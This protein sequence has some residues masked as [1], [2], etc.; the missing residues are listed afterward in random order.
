MKLAVKLLVFALYAIC[1]LTIE[2]FAQSKEISA[3]NKSFD[4]GNYP[5]AL[6]WYDLALSNPA[7]IKDKLLVEALMKRGT[8]RIKL[9]VKYDAN[10]N[11]STESRIEVRDLAVGAMTDINRAL[12]KDD[13][14]KLAD[15]INSTMQWIDELL[16]E[17]AHAR[18][19]EATVP[20][21]PFEEQKPSLEDARDF[22][23][24]S[25]RIDKFNYDMHRTK[26]ESELMLG[27]SA[28]ALGSFKLAADNFFRS[29]PKGGDLEIGYIYIHIAELEWHLN[30]DLRTASEAVDEGMMKLDRESSKIQNLGGRRPSEKASQSMRYTQ[31]KNDLMKA[32]FMVEA[33]ARK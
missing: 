8:A 2:S 14:G 31:V 30:G 16:V 24:A 20:N 3:G 6:K 21:L 13:D 18:F 5:D 19:K 33:N 28:A 26:G 7:E 25:L 10:H 15:D 12:D 1:F 17:F 11:H 23:T 22:A 27:D 9:A 32:Q 4:K 29:S